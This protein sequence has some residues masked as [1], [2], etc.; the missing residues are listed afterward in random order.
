MSYL[1]S[2]AMIK[3][4]AVIAWPA[5]YG[6]TG[7]MTVQVDRSGIGAEYPLSAW[8]PAPPHNPRVRDN[9]PHETN[10][11]NSVPTCRVRG[12]GRL[13]GITCA[14]PSHGLE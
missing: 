3:G 2:A 5:E 13:A 4:F 8:T 9:V 7:V 1:D 14:H 11:W 10:C 6:V 12:L